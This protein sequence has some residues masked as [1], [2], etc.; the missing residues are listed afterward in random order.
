MKGVRAEVLATP[1]YL[2]TSALITLFVPEPDSDSLNASLAGL[3][4]V[5]VSDLSLTEMASALGRRVRGAELTAT[6]ARRLYRDAQGLAS[7]CRGAELTRDTHRLA[8]RL[9]L[10]SP[11]PLRS[12][13]ALHLALALLGGAATLASYDGRLR[14]AASR[15]SLFVAPEGL[16]EVAHKPTV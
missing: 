1:V 7:S 4:D 6:A 13:D 12:L 16:Q 8:E 15:Q 11:L 9:L 14:E 5:I 2:E 3:D 10:T